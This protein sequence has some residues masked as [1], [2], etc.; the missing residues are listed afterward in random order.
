[1]TNEETL[2]VLSTNLAEAI[3]AAI[4]PAVEAITTRALAADL[5]SSEEIAEAVV[6]RERAERFTWSDGDYELELAP[7]EDPADTPAETRRYELYRT[8]Y[9]F[10]EYDPNRSVAHRWRARDPRP[11][12]GTAR[13]VLGYYEHEHEALF[14]VLGAMFAGR[15]AGVAAGDLETWLAASRR[16]AERVAAEPERSAYA[17]EIPPAVGGAE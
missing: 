6:D 16:K 2:A 7:A 3:A 4:A 12:N 5:P 11:H 13:P 8:R 9:R 14:A 15:S 1:M 10:V 17:Y